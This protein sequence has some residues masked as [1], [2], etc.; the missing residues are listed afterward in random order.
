M[1]WEETPE[2][3]WRAND[4]T[5]DYSEACIMGVWPH[6]KVGHYVSVGRDRDYALIGK[7]TAVR[8][9]LRN[10]AIVSLD[11][12]VDHEID[13]ASVRLE[14]EMTRTDAEL[15]A[16]AL[17]RV[18]GLAGRP[19][20]SDATALVAMAKRVLDVTSHKVS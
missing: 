6:V 1:T 5:R 10:D 12:D 7:V 19:N 2:R 9:G 17:D 15:V 16:R 4:W 18:R 14:Y 11:L 3:K 20:R 8:R 13:S